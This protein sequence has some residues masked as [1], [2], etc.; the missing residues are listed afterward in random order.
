MILVNQKWKQDSDGK[1]LMNDYDK[2]EEMNNYFVNIGTKLAEEF[3]HDSGASLN[4]PLASVNPGTAVLDQVAFSEAQIK[5]KLT[6]IKQK[7]GGPDKITS[8]DMAVASV[9]LKVSLASLKIVFNV[10][11]SP[12]SGRLERLSRNTRKG[13]D[14]TVQT[15]DRWQCLIWTAKFWRTLSAIP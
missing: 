14:Q 4:Q 5:L 7:T 1:I 3:H 12:I 15:T 11:F 8:R 9:A 13:L 2:A 10:A 6:H